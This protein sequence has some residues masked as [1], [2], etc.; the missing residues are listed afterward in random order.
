MRGNRRSRSLTA[1]ERTLLVAG[2]VCV[3]WYGGRTFEIH[4]QQDEARRAVAR[5]VVA[6]ARATGVGPPPALMDERVMGRIDIPSIRLSAAIV[7]TDDDEALGFAVGYLPDTP[8][9]WAPGNS[10]F[11]AHRDELFRPLQ[12]VQAGDQISLTTRRGSLRYR[13]LR[14]LIV[15]PSDVWVRSLCKL[16]KLNSVRPTVASAM[17]SISILSRAGVRSSSSATAAISSQC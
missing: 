8:P 7:D 3:S 15:R 13:V 16:P 11:A 9:P 4:R 5:I 6:P 12:H 10:V 14:T 2:V 17:S 1:I